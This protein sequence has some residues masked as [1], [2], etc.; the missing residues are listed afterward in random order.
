MWAVASFPQETQLRPH[1]SQTYSSVGKQYSRVPWHSGLWKNGLGNWRTEVTCLKFTEGSGMQLCCV[2]YQKPEVNFFRVR[3]QAHGG[4]AGQSLPLLCGWLPGPGWRRTQLCR[5][6]RQSSIPAAMSISFQIYPD[7]FCIMGVIMGGDF[8]LERSRQWESGVGV[9][10][11][12][13]HSNCLVLGLVLCG[14]WS[15]HHRGSNV[16]LFST[17]TLWV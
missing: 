3:G 17:P 8:S 9:T 4:D 16:K 14:S 6:K 5:V 12:R 7:S 15:V 11:H 2:L 1:I 10:L 13:V